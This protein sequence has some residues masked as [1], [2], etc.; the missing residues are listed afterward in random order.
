[1][2]LKQF[3]PPN[4]MQTIGMSAIDF[5]RMTGINVLKTKPS[6]SSLS[7]VTDQQPRRPQVTLPLKPLDLSAS[8][9]DTIDRI[10]QDIL[11]KRTI[12]SQYKGVTEL[13]SPSKRGPTP[14]Q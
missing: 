13:Y 8:P 7:D 4:P 9:L 11:S 6:E 10:R 14:S 12:E 3:Q 5:S 1:M 2:A